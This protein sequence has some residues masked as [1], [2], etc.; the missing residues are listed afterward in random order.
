VISA[1]CEE[2]MDSV[3][4]EAVERFDVLRMHVMV[5][6]EEGAIHV[7]GSK[8]E[9]GDVRERGRMIHGVFYG[10]GCG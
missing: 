4:P 9:F 10:R 8:A 2:D 3:V 5:G 7:K 6:T 1:T